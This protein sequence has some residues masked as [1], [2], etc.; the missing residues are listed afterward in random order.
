MNTYNS[1]NELSAANCSGPLQSQMSVFNKASHPYLT[2]I[3][4]MVDRMG[5]HLATLKEEASSASSVNYDDNAK[6][7]PHF[8]DEHVRNLA[9]DIHVI[10]DAMYNVMEFYKTGEDR[11][12]VWD[13]YPEDPP[14]AEEVKPELK[15][16]YATALKY[17]S[18]FPFKEANNLFEDGQPQNSYQLGKF[19]DAFADFKNF[20][21]DF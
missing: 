16:L 2:K 13:V 5:N 4:K 12:G 18:A 14:S 6:E 9:D 21:V 7:Y 17:A 3:T 15:K 20:S 19:E 11:E 8:F 10:A 1:F